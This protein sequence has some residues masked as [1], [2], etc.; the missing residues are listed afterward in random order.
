M[1]SV[2]LG[3]NDRTYTFKFVACRS[4]FAG[5]GLRTPMDLA[6][7]SNDVVYILNRSYE[8]RIDGCRITVIS[9]TDAGEEYIS[10]FGSYGHGDGQFVYPMGIALDGDENVYVTDEYLHRVNVYNKDGEF[11]RRWGT[12]GSGNGQLNGPAGIAIRDGTAFV[13]DSRSHRVQKFGLDGRYRG[14]FGSFGQ[15]KEQ[16]NMPWGICLDR[17]GNV[18]VAD[19]RNDRIQSF[20]P[21]GQWLMSIG[22]PGS[23]GDATV[24]RW[25]GGIRVVDR[26]VGLFNRPTGVAVDQDGDIYVADWWNNRVQVLTPEGRFI[27]QFTGDAGLSKWG[28]DKIKSNPEMIQQRNGVRDFSPEK[29][30]WAPVTVKVDD[31]KRWIIIADTTRHRLQ[32]YQK[33]RAPVLFPGTPDHLAAVPR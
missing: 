10:E 26:Q 15:E 28:V 9:L 4:E 1:A 33:N 30:L 3:I 6:L 22:Q 14:Q 13:V 2:F 31:A 5:T 20:T 19:W 18:W 23:G 25:Y 8:S 32:V 11:L 7:A 27:T 16:L 29:V 17:E 24:P 21:N 12:P